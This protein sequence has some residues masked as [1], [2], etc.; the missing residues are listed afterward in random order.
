MENL[1]DEITD[2]RFWCIMKEQKRKSRDL[3]A[4]KKSSP[5]RQWII[6][7]QYQY[8]KNDK[9]YTKQKTQELKNSN[10][11]RRYR[12]AI[13]K[14]IYTVFQSKW[15]QWLQSYLSSLWLS[16]NQNTQN[17]L[18][19]TIQQE[20]LQQYSTDKI[21]SQSLFTFLSKQPMTALSSLFTSREKLTES[22]SPNQQQTTLQLIDKRVSDTTLEMTIPNT[23][24]KIQQVC[25]WL[26]AR[27][28]ISFCCPDYPGSFVPWTNTRKYSMGDIG[29]DIWYFG[30]KV[31]QM[32]T[33]VWEDIYQSFWALEKITIIMPSYQYYDTFDTFDKSQYQNFTTKIL[34]TGRKLAKNVQSYFAQKNIP[35][36]VSVKLSSD[37]YS[38]QKLSERIEDISKQTEDLV[39]KN[40]AKEYE[41]L[42]KV[43]KATWNTTAQKEFLSYTAEWSLL[44]ELFD[45]TQTL[46]L[47]PETPQ[48]PKLVME[49]QEF[50]SQEKETVWLPTLIIQ[51]DRR[52]DTSA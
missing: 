8:L 4:I 33:M 32:L 46:F 37:L 40:F 49:V 34:S 3:E 48:M 17:T 50:Q 26:T 7:E 10:T 16:Y 13:K 6:D 22:M 39:Q 51:K 28:M 9:K 30:S 5:D 23:P 36:Q 38:D 11:Y 12:E 43:E 25:K 15:F 35:I 41:K 1:Y 20:Y 29:D 52:W 24:K 31:E 21:I 14:K 45:P 2:R 27:E 47:M 19:K 18:I 42:M 44:P